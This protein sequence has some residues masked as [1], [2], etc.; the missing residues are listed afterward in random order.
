MEIPE[1]A[2]IEERTTEED[3]RKAELLNRPL[4]V[5]EL[6]HAG[7]LEKDGEWYKILKYESL[8][9]HARLKINE[10]TIRN[11]KVFAKFVVPKSE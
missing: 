7:I 10:F 6:I 5:D 9:K 11:N 2:I 8:P 4:D 3:R 1:E